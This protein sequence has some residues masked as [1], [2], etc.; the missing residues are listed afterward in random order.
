MRPWSVHAANDHLGSVPAPEERLL[1]VVAE[2]EGQPPGHAANDHLWSV[3]AADERLQYLVAANEGQP[4]VH[5]AN[6]H[7]AFVQ[8]VAVEHLV[9]ELQ[10]EFVVGLEPQSHIRSRC[11]LQGSYR[12]FAHRLSSM[13]ESMIT[14]R[15]GSQSVPCNRFKCLAKLLVSKIVLQTNT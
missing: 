12:P 1:A 6:E 10:S 14:R 11:L 2:N 15:G 7:Q 5:A 8:R 9:V 3:V 13:S 4:P